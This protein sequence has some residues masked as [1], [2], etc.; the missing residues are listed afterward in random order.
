MFCKNCGAQIQEN[1]TFCPECGKVVSNQGTDNQSPKDDPLDSEQL[2][3]KKNGKSKFIL[4]VLAAV[5]VIV[6]VIFTSQKQPVTDL[7]NIIFDSYGISTFGE[8]VEE[9]VRNTTWN[10]EEI[11][12]THY[13]VTVSG[14]IPATYSNIEFSFDLNYVDD[15]VYASAKD[16]VVDG[17]Y[18]NDSYTISYVMDA[19]YG[20]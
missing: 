2:N 1:V 19:I 11:D 6:V 13:V 5:I 10:S 7:Q 3:H 15:T 16:V 8:A 12:S 14:F 17:D 20:N 18:Y 9:N 4:G